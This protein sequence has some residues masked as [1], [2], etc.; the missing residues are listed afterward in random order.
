MEK[1]KDQV[2][3]LQDLKR[4]HQISSFR[5]YTSDSQS[6]LLEL[7]TE[8]IEKWPAEKPF[9]HK[10]HSYLSNVRTLAS[11]NIKDLCLLY[12]EILLLINKEQI[13]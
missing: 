12:K 1:L 5:Y 4:Q 9:P 11:E 7:I 3:M 8:E 13:F 10:L 2:R 6:I